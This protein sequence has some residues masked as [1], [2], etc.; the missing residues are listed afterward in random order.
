[1]KTRGL[2]ASTRKAPVG[3]PVARCKEVSTQTMLNMDELDRIMM[4]FLC[5]RTEACTQTEGTCL[6]SLPVFDIT[7]DSTGDHRRVYNDSCLITEM[8]DNSQDCDSSD[9]GCA[10]SGKRKQDT[11]VFQAS[12]DCMSEKESPSSGKSPVLTPRTSKRLALKRK[13]SHSNTKIKCGKKLSDVGKQKSSACK[14]NR[15]AIDDGVCKSTE[16]KVDQ[17]SGKKGAT[18]SIVKSEPDEHTSEQ[19]KVLNLSDSEDKNCHGSDK[20]DCDS[21]YTKQQ[22]TLPIESNKRLHICKFCS[23]TFRD[24]T[25]FMRHNRMHTKEKPY[26]CEQCD[27]SFRWKASYLAHLRQVHQV[28]SRETSPAGRDEN[29]TGLL[30][31]SSTDGSSVQ[32]FVRSRRKRQKRICKCEFCGK[33]LRCLA[34]L[35]RHML[36]HTGTRPFPCNQC[37]RAFSERSGLKVIYLN[38]HAQS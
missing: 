30:N 12:A 14:T 25:D 35:N 37:P 17:S 18:L 11:V 6:E 21:K 24:V 15:L 26:P 5:P 29:S 9:G 16:S 1:M 7:L 10:V 36:T 34:N 33:V 2:A 19:T 31:K 20:T 28:S 13:L 3:K 22:N 4:L 38:N 8:G 32:D 27:S 23:R